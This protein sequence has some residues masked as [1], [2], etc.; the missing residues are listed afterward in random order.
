MCSYSHGL[1]PTAKVLE[2]EL[3]MLQHQSSCLTRVSD[4]HNSP[5]RNLV[6][7]SWRV[8]EADTNTLIALVFNARKFLK[9]SSRGAVMDQTACLHIR[10]PP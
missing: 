8:S 4:G 6:P 7:G 10:R 3:N 5:T 9:E 2:A 1:L